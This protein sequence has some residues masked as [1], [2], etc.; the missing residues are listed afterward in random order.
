MI[1]IHCDF[2]LACKEA[3]TQFER[4]SPFGVCF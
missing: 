1:M 3:Q 2:F 4:Y